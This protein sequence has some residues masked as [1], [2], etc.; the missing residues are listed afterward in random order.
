MSVEQVDTQQLMKK[1]KLFEAIVN[2]TQ[3]GILVFNHLG[4]VI[5]GNA[6]AGHYLGI[7]PEKLRGK[8]LST[9]IPIEKREKHQ[10]LVSLFGESKET[11]QN[12]YDWNEIQCR[13]IDGSLFP[14]KITIHKYN[15]SEKMVYI[16]SI[17][18]MTEFAK[19]EAEKHA[20]EIRLFQAEQQK[21][22]SAFTLQANMEKAI[23]Q[24]AKTAQSVK[25]TKSNRYV[26]E[27]MNSIMQNA[28]TAISL[29]QKAVFFSDPGRR[30]EQ[31]NLVDQSL[32]GSI[33]RSRVIVQAQIG[34]KDIAIEWEVP[35]SA[36]GYKLQD[37]QRIEQI[38]FNIIEDAVSNIKTGQISVHLEELLI[39]DNENLQINFTCKSPHFGIPQHTMDRVLNASSMRAVP[40]DSEL[41]N[42][43]KCL[44]LAKFLVEKNNGSMRVVTHPINGTQIFI[45][46]KE[47]LLKTV[48]NKV[49][50]LAEK[51]DN[52]NEEPKVE[53]KQIDNE[54]SLNEKPDKI[55][56]V[57]I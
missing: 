44:R 45:H 27:Q 52:K 22:C 6:G 56:T 2:R 55:Q 17:R 37:C 42:D 40:K 11:R 18:D 3:D 35:E 1:I 25:D 20:A 16:V 31:L 23:T 5:Y 46:L 19:L 48:A 41:K 21:K 24:I 47:P 34:K 30:S 38:M 51:H 13:R 33:E 14:A 43:G 36:R 12:H 4:E 32:Y 9:F 57:A 54:A 7:A 49:S 10:M 26:D 29:S 28:F 8:P 15:I 50:N 53:E 39:E